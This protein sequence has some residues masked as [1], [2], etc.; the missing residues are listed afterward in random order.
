VEMQGRI[1][2]VVGKHSTACLQNHSVR[3]NGVILAQLT[4][5]FLAGRTISLGEAHDVDRGVHGRRG[6]AVP[7]A[8]APEDKKQADDLFERHFV[9]KPLLHHLNNEESQ[10]PTIQICFDK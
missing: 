7:A 2:L 6:V 9:R 4:K 1:F 8:D 3:R 5:E 10:S